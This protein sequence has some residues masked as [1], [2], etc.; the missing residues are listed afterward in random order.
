M[1]CLMTEVEGH[2]GEAEAGL[3]GINELQAPPNHR[4]LPLRQPC[5]C[6]PCLPSPSLTQGGGLRAVFSKLSVLSFFLFL[7]STVW[8]PLH[9]FH[10]LIPRAIP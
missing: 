2:S 1:D 9:L 3:Y 4:R 10:S 8:P 5:R 7:S 6:W